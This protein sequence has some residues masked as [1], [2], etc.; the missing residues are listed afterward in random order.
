MSVGAGRYKNIAFE[1]FE[2]GGEAKTIHLVILAAQAYGAEK[3]WKKVSF[4]D[5]S[6]QDDLCHCYLD[7]CDD[8]LSHYPDNRETWYSNVVI[9]WGL[10]RF[11]N[12]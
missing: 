5:S 7:F 8:H 4:G 2:D 11:G 1:Y 3:I 9:Q 6:T 10:S 12:C